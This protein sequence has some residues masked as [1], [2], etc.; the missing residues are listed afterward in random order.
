MNA[1]HEVR[2]VVGVHLFEGFHSDPRV[3]ANL[4]RV[5]PSDSEPS[6][7]AVASRVRDDVGL[8]AGSASIGGKGFVDRAYRLPVKLDDVFFGPC[9]STAE[10]APAT[11]AA[12]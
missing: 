9:A 11:M 6:D 2:M 4:V 8:E 7:A 5:D 3:S 10:G 12:R 1:G